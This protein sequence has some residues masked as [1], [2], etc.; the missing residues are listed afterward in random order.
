MCGKVL[1][2]VLVQAIL[3][4]HCCTMLTLFLICNFNYDFN[5][6]IHFLVCVKKPVQKALSTAEICYKFVKWIELRGISTSDRVMWP[7]RFFFKV[8][9]KLFLK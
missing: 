6:I 1:F 2:C 9:K 4:H 8:F 3:G 5:D 7:L